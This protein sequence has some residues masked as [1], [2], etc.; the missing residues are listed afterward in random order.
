MGFKVFRPLGFQ[1]VEVE[2]LGLHDWALPTDEPFGLSLCKAPNN[3]QGTFDW[4]A[5]MEL[6]LG[7]YDKITLLVAIYSIIIRSR[8]LSPL[9]ANQL[10]ASKT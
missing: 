3:R 10:R 4:V 2:V 6:E 5:A 9:P 1:G 8:D 7:Y